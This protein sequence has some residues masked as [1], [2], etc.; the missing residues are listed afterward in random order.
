MFFPGAN[1]FSAQQFVGS[2]AM[3]AL[4]CLALFGHLHILH[5]A[6]ALFEVAEGIVL[7]SFSIFIVQST[8]LTLIYRLIQTVG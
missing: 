4:T 8:A 5:G 7:I 1:P 3:L 6:P 2:G